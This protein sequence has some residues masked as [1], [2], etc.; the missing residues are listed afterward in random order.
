MNKNEL[1]FSGIGGQGTILMGQYVCFAASEKGY[2]VTLA[3][4]YGQE[5]RGGRA[6]CQVVISEEMDSPVISEADTILVLDEASFDDYENRVK[7]GGTLIVNSSMVS[8]KSVRD[9][10]R[11]IEVPFTAIATD[12]GNAKSS[13]MVALGAVVKTLHLVGLDDLREVIR[14]RMKPAMV[15]INIKALEAGYNT[16]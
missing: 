2:A 13:N 11:V 9:D 14:K 10:I 8:R 6:S 12:L 15:D 1:I 4:A 5:K 16:L 3:P 7:P